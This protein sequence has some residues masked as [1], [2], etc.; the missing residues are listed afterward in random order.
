MA[1]TTLGIRVYY[2]E[3]TVT[4]GV[5]AIPA[6]WTEIPEITSIPAM[7]S[8]P[9]K[10]DVTPISETVMK[11]YKSG[12]MD[13]G[14]SLE[15]KA[16]HTPELESVVTAAAAAPAAGKARAFSI[17]YPA[18]LS[19][20]QWWTGQVQKIKPGEAGVNGALTTSIYIST[21]TAVQSAVAS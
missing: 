17:V 11:V 5:P 8:A 3:A 12:L 15:F 4:N 9:E 13:L 1:Q 14:G 19:Q 2:G 6:T 10:I 18:P 7:S 16:N 20:R 21:E